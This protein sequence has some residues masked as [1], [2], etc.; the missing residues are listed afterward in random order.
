MHSTIYEVDDDVFQITTE[1]EDGRIT[2]DILMG[3]DAF[4]AHTQREMNTQ[5]DRRNDGHDF[6]A[7]SYSRRVARGSYRESL[8]H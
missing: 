3:R 1:H 6:L 5:D 8:Q 2:V 4:E 7:S